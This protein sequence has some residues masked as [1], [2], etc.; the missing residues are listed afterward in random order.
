MEFGVL[1]KGKGH[2]YI[3]NKKKTK[4]NFLHACTTLWLAL[5]QTTEGSSEGDDKREMCKVGTHCIP[6]SYFED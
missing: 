1:K 2:I 5:V 4:R 3:Y 6:K